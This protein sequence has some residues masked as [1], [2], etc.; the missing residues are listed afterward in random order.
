MKSFIFNFT[1]MVEDQ[2][3]VVFM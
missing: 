1:T 2:T 3:P